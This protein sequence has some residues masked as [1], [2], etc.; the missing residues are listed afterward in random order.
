MAEV[1]SSLRPPLI[2]GNKKPIDVSNDICEII[3][4]K[5]TG[6]WW[7]AFSVSST[8]LLIGTIAVIYQ[9]STGIGTWG[10][11]KSV[12]W[13]FDITNF[14]F[15]IGI[16]HAGT[17]ISA[18]LYLVRAPFRNSIYRASEAMTGAFRGDTGAVNKVLFSMDALGDAFI[19]FYHLATRAAEVQPARQ[20][21]GV[22]W[23]DHV[24]R[25]L[26]LRSA[27]VAHQQ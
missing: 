27:L 3:E 22:R 21:H 8:M 25:F 1:Q 23:R 6:M 5:P 2:L 7:A 13:A 20:D 24:R 18:V 26:Q 9:I 4:R 15:W 16:G 17:L 11:N 14:V 12:G 10:L 19:P